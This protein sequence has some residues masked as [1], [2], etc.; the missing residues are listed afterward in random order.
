MA[1]WSDSFSRSQRHALSRVA[2]WHAGRERSQ[3]TPSACDTCHRG[4]RVGSTRKSPPT[5]RPGKGSEN[6][7]NSTPTLRGVQGTIPFTSSRCVIPSAGQGRRIEPRGAS[8]ARTGER[9]RGSVVPMPAR[10]RCPTTIG[11]GRGVRRGG[12]NLPATRPG[13]APTLQPSFHRDPK[14]RGVKNLVKHLFWGDT[15]RVKEPAGNGSYE[16]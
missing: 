10:R 2:G 12:G 7:H 15:I 14:G 1:G 3:P 5:A 13:S 6:R 8:G 4:V 9:S 16:A 11:D